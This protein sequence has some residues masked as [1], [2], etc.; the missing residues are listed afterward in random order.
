MGP[1]TQI[2]NGLPPVLSDIRGR[3]KKK[4]P[5]SLALVFFLLSKLKTPQGAVR[6]VRL[7]VVARRAIETGFVQ[8][9]RSPDG[10]TLPLLP[11]EWSISG[12]AVPLYPWGKAYQ[13]FGHQSGGIQIQ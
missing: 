9:R 11:T 10:Q 1:H 3:T 6:P 7:A 13:T 8:P 4:K 12:A 5:P 2:R